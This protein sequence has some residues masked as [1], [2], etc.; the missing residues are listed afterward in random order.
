MRLQFLQGR[1][2]FVKIPVQNRW[3]SLFLQEE[4]GANTR[5]FL[6]GI[7]AIG[8]FYVIARALTTGTQ[9]L[10]GRW[11]GPNEYGLATL[12]IACTSVLTI[13]LQLG[14]PAAATKFPAMESSQARQAE[15]ISTAVWA[16]ML[17]GLPCAGFLYLFTDAIS[18][19][20]RLSPEVYGW[21][22]LASCLFALNS[23]V[24]SALQGAKRFPERGRVE[25]VYAAV[26]AVAFGT[27][28]L[29]VGARFT[30]LAASLCV[31]LAAS[32]TL[33][34]YYLR[35]L[36]RPILSVHALSCIRSY[37]VAPVLNSV[38]SAMV[39]GSTPIILATYMSE[40]EVGI[41][42]IYSLGTIMIA[43]A[44]SVIVSTVLGPLSSTSTGQ[45][46]AWRKFFKAVP[47]LFPCGILFFALSNVVVLLVV[48]KEYPM[49]VLWVLLFALAATLSFL[50]SATLTLLFARDVRG[51]WFGVGGMILSG[52]GCI[53]GNLVAIPRYAV[54]GAALSLV[55]SY[56][57]GLTWC[58]LFGWRDL[59]SKERCG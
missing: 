31:G 44:F 10:A 15:I 54:S 7:Y 21:G 36:I 28:Y 38:A 45:E 8:L 23:L 13:P 20:L 4:M 16:N 5:A 37:T 1:M 48:G 6:E 42:S 14:F 29:I 55:L 49:Q 41:L 43:G 25:A 50:F 24:C 9:I 56:S 40:R 57:I 32:A 51:L 11:L 22:L 12:V 17:W 3:L 30:S 35:N 26:F 59:R 47:I 2:S 52:I 34:I 19:I 58:V 27:G 53:V 39:M 33:A 18:Q 46:G